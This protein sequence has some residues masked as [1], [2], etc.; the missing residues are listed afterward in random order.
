MVIKDMSI[1]FLKDNISEVLEVFLLDANFIVINGLD[2]SMRNYLSGFVLK[3]SSMLIIVECDYGDY[4]ML[5]AEMDR[6]KSIPRQLTAA[7]AAAA[8]VNSSPPPST[9]P[10]FGSFARTRINCPAKWYVDGA[11]YFADVFDALEQATEEIFICD[12]WL[13]PELH[14]KRP[15]D[16][17]H[18]L[19]N[20]LQRRAD[21]GVKIC[22]L[23]YKEVKY[24]LKIDSWYTKLVL[25]ERNKRNIFVLRHPD[26]LSTWE[27]LWGHHEK[28]VVVDQKLAFVGGLDLCW[29]RWDTQQHR[30]ADN[31]DDNWRKYP[32]LI[33]VL[34][35]LALEMDS[36][37]TPTPAESSPNQSGQST[38]NLRSAISRHSNHKLTGDL[39][40]AGNKRSTKVQVHQ[41]QQQQN[42]VSMASALEQINETDSPDV[43]QASSEDS[44][45]AAAAAAAAAAA[46]AAAENIGGVSR[47][48]GSGAAS[49]RV[50]RFFSLAQQLQQLQRGGRQQQ[51]ADW[52]DK[53]VADPDQLTSSSDFSNLQ[54]SATQPTVALRRAYE[55]HLQS[56]AAAAAA[57]AVAAT[58]SVAEDETDLKAS[59]AKR[60][61]D[62]QVQVRHH[63]PVMQR[64]GNFLRSNRERR[65]V[66]RDVRER[67]KR[68]DETKSLL[69][70]VD[71]NFAIRPDEVDKIQ[72]WKGKD[73]VNWLRKEPVRMDQ[74]DEELVDRGRV[75]RM[76]WHDIGCV[77]GGN[78]A[79]DLSRHFIERWN[80]TVKNKA[81]G[82]GQR[83]NSAGRR[84][85]RP[86][87]LIPKAL[88]A[89]CPMSSDAADA[90]QDDD[91]DFQQQQQFDEQQQKR[92][93]KKEQSNT[94]SLRSFLERN[95]HSHQEGRQEQQAASTGDHQ[96]QQ[97]LRP[98]PLPFK[99]I[100]PKFANRVTV[101][102]S[103][104]MWSGGIEEP[105][106]SILQAMSHAIDTAEH[107]VYIENQFF[108]SCPDESLGRSKWPVQNP[109]ASRLV[110]RIIRA[111]SEGRP[112]RAYLVLPLLPQFE[113]DIS[114]SGSSG[115]S[116]KKIMHH[117][118]EC[119]CRSEHSVMSRLL[120]AGIPIE[121]YLSVCS[122]RTWGQLTGGRLST[123]LI[124]IHSKLLIADDR[125]A[126][127]GSANINDRS[128]L[129][130][131]D[132]ELAVRFE[133][134]GP[135]LLP[136]EWQGCGRV[137]TGAF[138]GSLRRCIM[139]EH[140]GVQ[141]NDP[142]DRL[143]SDP[144]GEALFNGLWR[145]TAKRNTEIYETVFRCYPTDR[146]VNYRQLKQWTGE[147]GLAA[148]NRDVALQRLE[149]E[150]RGFL[151]EF[152]MRFLEGVNLDFP[153][154]R[155]TSASIVPLITW[156]IREEE[157][158]SCENS[159]EESDS[160]FDDDEA[161]QDEAVQELPKYP[162][163]PLYTIEHPSEVQPL[164]RYCWCCCCCCCCTSLGCTLI[165]LA[166][167]SPL[168]LAAACLLCLPLLFFYLLS[169]ARA[170]DP[171]LAGPRQSE[172]L[173]RPLSAAELAWFTAPEPTPALVAQ[174]DIRD[175]TSRRLTFVALRSIVRRHL[176][177]LPRLRQRIVRLPDG[178]A[179]WLELPNFDS[180]AHLV[181][182]QPRLESA[183]HLTEYL[184][185]CSG[186]SFSDDRP[187]W[188]LHYQPAGGA[189][190][191]WRARR[192]LLIYRQHACF[193]DGASALRLLER[194]LCDSRALDE[195]S[196]TTTRTT[197]TQL[198]RQ[199][200]ASESATST[201]VTTTAAAVAAWARAP[202]LLLRLARANA[203]NSPHL[204]TATARDPR[205]PMADAERKAAAAAAASAA[206]AAEDAARAGEETA[207]ST[208]LWQ[209]RLDSCLMRRAQQVTQSS[210][211]D[212]FL[213]LLAGALRSYQQL[214]GVEVPFDCRAIIDCA[215]QL[216]FADVE[217]DVEPRWRRLPVCRRLALNAEGGLPR[218][219]LTR[220]QSHRFRSRSSRD[221]QNAAV[222]AAA[223][224]LLD[225]GL[226]QRLIIGGDE[227]RRDLAQRLAWQRWQQRRSSRWRQQPAGPAEEAAGPEDALLIDDNDS[228]EEGIVSSACRVV[229]LQAGATV[230]S[231]PVQLDAR[232]VSGVAIWCP[233]PTAAAP[234]SATLTV[235]AGQYRVALA[236]PAQLRQPGLIA[237]C[238]RN[239][240]A[241]LS[242][243][244]GHRRVSADR[245]DAGSPTPKAAVPLKSRSHPHLL[246]TLLSSSP[247]QTEEE[248]QQRLAEVQAQLQSS[249]EL[250]EQ[251]QQQ[252]PQLRLE[253]C[254]VMSE[255]RRRRSDCGLGDFDDP[256][257]DRPP[258]APPVTRRLSMAAAAVA[259]GEVSAGRRRSSIVHQHL[260]VPP[261]HHRSRATANIVVV[262][263]R[264]IEAEECEARRQAEAWG[265]SGW[266]V[267]PS[268][269]VIFRGEETGSSS[270]PKE[271][272]E[273]WDAVGLADL[274]NGRVRPELCSARADG[275]DFVLEDCR[276]SASVLGMRGNDAA[277]DDDADPK[278]G[279]TVFD[280][281][282]RVAVD[283]LKIQVAAAV[284][285]VFEAEVGV[286]QKLALSHGP[287]GQETN[288][289]VNQTAGSLSRFPADKYVLRGNVEEGV[290]VIVRSRRGGS[291]SSLELARTAI[292]RRKNLTMST[293]DT[294]T[295]APVN[296]WEL[297]LSPTLLSLLAVAYTVVFA[298][299][300]IGNAAVIGTVYRLPSMHTAI[301]YFICNLSTADI[302]MAIFCLPLNLI[303][304]TF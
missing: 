198:G 301:N 228:D 178:S 72:L 24:T 193:G 130:Y 212:L 153:V 2:P 276:E 41:Q 175:P 285:Q 26:H 51:T 253:F 272:D 282:I 263:D 66:T 296:L 84:G 145:E 110:D 122:M 302:L 3:N 39:G 181:E 173:C 68:G 135:D 139:R 57:A 33:P 279:A 280:G 236:A 25:R 86:P 134:A 112:F 42:S 79:R 233:V 103:L 90:E 291:L 30:I 104:G 140:L 43:A 82:V 205:N 191:R 176:A 17:Y 47:S 165:G 121:D 129:G 238:L 224:R 101:L 184:R 164:A 36:Q 243:L 292:R 124:Y 19:M 179:A 67:L 300:L 231:Q 147:P 93:D 34:T 6:I 16:G 64:M 148:T 35:N 31:G 168:G 46:E 158:Q 281:S 15:D 249:S 74:P 92:W 199:W 211:Q 119:L 239:Q 194:G 271:L 267:G 242:Q 160:N 126:I 260:L 270:R 150:V 217:A 289:G 167:L 81:N 40:S 237:R 22:I 252:Q 151:V 94:W 264:R 255:L 149:G 230:G 216:H 21:A 185:A 100:A 182:I 55:L 44:V 197:T 76:P 220:R 159:T 256:E 115:E 200:T 299:S 259:A 235:Y 69:G 203:A 58:S 190:A 142:K 196:T 60:L 123:E 27:F 229:C 98:R 11:T 91:D 97:P 297:N 287:M 171:N 118:Y 223:S 89:E 88:K 137:L 52:V 95:H 106:T 73:Y 226:V 170:S 48:N 29:G 113:G 295:D 215:E 9:V 232:L 240:L 70:D 161:E 269:S 156:L 127:I 251:Q 227:R 169:A 13:T 152:P 14:L 7:A 189:D 28:L 262:T 109:I 114:E 213:S 125:V 54:L 117:T 144:V 195:T 1:I 166:L 23:I 234:L 266:S 163:A 201:A 221:G 204:A 38:P 268:C 257:L 61:R 132:S 155:I 192:G 207:P 87:L 225:N 209:L 111:H 37:A 154:G 146:V 131:R 214:L 20:V 83:R 78:A 62:G 75:P 304:N 96:Q 53:P 63:D 246:E 4:P 202:C 274:V 71:P 183:A 102:R 85:N 157:A 284:S 50:R 172:L 143:L 120:L 177:T 59:D 294:L 141:W 10:E 45:V 254:R 186:K 56:E 116:I 187:P 8:A 12:W 162:V 80:F 303:A 206:K 248:L 77:V 288:A 136:A 283:L 286:G 65:R 99:S 258:P 275:K 265:R 247:S 293:N 5:S 208:R 133:D 188:E 245:F 138:C 222:S 107:Y 298:L 278:A 218:L 261:A 244:L 273:P 49:E 210:D 219:W 277:V 128:L 32:P 174:L 250:P 290:E 241:A 105:E 108:I 180:D 18:Q